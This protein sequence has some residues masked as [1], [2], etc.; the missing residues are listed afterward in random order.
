MPRA[1]W[2]QV[3]RDCNSQDK[4]ELKQ[5]GACGRTLCQGQKKLQSREE[6]TPEADTEDDTGILTNV[7]GLVGLFSPLL[8]PLLKKGL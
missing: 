2:R 6:P 4:P 7:L 5:K 8:V 3:E 1:D